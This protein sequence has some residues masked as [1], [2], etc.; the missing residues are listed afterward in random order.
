MTYD[1]NEIFDEIKDLP[2]VKALVDCYKNHFDFSVDTI[3]VE[4]IDEF[5]QCII[6]LGFEDQFAIRDAHGTWREAT[7]TECIALSKGELPGSFTL[8]N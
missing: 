5:G 8:L 3:R 2:F 7:A 6:W 4:T 1:A